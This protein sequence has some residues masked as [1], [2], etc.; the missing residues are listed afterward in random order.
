MSGKN[1]TGQYA[2][3]GFQVHCNFRAHFNMYKKFGMHSALCPM[4]QFKYFVQNNW[5]IYILCAKQ[6]LLLPAASSPCSSRV[7]NSPNP[8]PLNVPWHT[9]TFH[10][11][12]YNAKPWETLPYQTPFP[13]AYHSITFN[14]SYFYL[15]HKT[16]LSVYL[17]L[18]YHGKEYLKIPDQHQTTRHITPRQCHSLP[19]FSTSTTTTIL[20]KMILPEKRG[21]LCNLIFS[22]STYRYRQEQF[23][24]FFFNL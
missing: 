3:L 21:A 7:T 15:P 16:T 19:Y 17:T 6:L 5:T 4:I 18:A 14:I 1:R 11:T 13:F 20:H 12:A 24:W 8:P 22:R 23:K 2:K 9:S 10:T